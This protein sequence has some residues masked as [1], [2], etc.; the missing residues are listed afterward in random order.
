[1]KYFQDD[2]KTIKNVLEYKRFSD[3][4]Q[5]KSLHYSIDLKIDNINSPFTK[6]KVIDPNRL[7]KENDII[8]I[9]FINKNSN[10]LFWIN[11]NNYLFL[12]HF[13]KFHEYNSLNYRKYFSDKLLLKLF[14]S[15]E[16]IDT[17]EYNE[18]LI[19]YIVAMTN[20]GFDL[21]KFVD[22]NNSVLYTLIDLDINDNFNYIEH[23][24]KKFI[25]VE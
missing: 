9:C 25:R 20:P 19:P 15:N 1:M 12:E 11:N 2:E 23:F 7:R 21:I 16:P 24:V 17:N 4:L 10:K 22:D 8:P 18:N 13:F 5:S 3:I 14:L 6:V